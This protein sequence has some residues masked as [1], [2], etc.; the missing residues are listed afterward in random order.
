MSIKEFN[1]LKRQAKDMGIDVPKGTKMADLKAKID[2]LDSEIE[3]C[4]LCKKPCDI[5]FCDGDP[6][7]DIDPEI[8]G[9][10]L[11]DTEEDKPLKAEDSYPTREAWLL[12]G[13]RALIPLAAQ[14]GAVVDPARV[15][16]SVGFGK[17]R[18][19]DA[20]CFPS[21][22]NAAGQHPVF[23]SP[24]N[25]D[26]VR[27]LGYILHELGHAS[28]DCESGHNG[29][30]AA[31][32]KAAGFEAPRTDS[33]LG[34]ALETALKEIAIELGPYPHVKMELSDIKKQKTYLVKMECECGLML[35]VT[36]KWIDK[37]A[38]TNPDGWPCPCGG[39]LIADLPDE[40]GNDDE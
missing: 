38:E 17:G 19:A 29:S 15:A 3:R 8:E 24:T 13:V 35:R 28:D 5:C 7:D 18:K 26:P 9:D 36:K 25:D 33:K 39:K 14:A 4:E 32:H 30:F 31:F 34:P 2:A 40:E 11:S 6:F 21:Q 37:Y 20:V 23:V 1:A 27:I 16:I 12:A 10:H 22:T